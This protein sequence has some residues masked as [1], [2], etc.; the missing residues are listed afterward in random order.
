MVIFVIFNLY[1]IVWMALNSV[2]TEQEF[3]RN[4]FGFPTGLLW[5][6]YV[7]AWKVANLG[8]FFINSVIITTISVVVTL[9]FGALAAFFLSRFEFRL[10]GLTLLYLTFGMLIP[11]H[12]TLVPLFIEMR[13]LGLLNTRMT[14]LFP[15]VAFNLPI[16]IFILASFM[17]AFPKEVEEAAI[18]DGCGVMDVFIRVILP[19]LIPALATAF[20]LD[21][22]NIWNEFSFALVL[23]SDINLKTLPLGLANFA[24]QYNSS[25]TLQMAGLTIVLI[26]TLL[27]YILVQKYLTAGMTAG[28]VKG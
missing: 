14:L 2:K 20:I 12:A 22:L 1:P 11:I 28:A 17:N 23:I 8:P 15:Y 9:I 24:G 27:F 13:S 25:Y 3:T 5:S 6:N 18:V 26:P 21:F 16:T 10:K 7:E 4:P 19:M